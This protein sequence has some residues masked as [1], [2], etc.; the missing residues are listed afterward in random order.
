[1]NSSLSKCTTFS[2]PIAFEAHVACFQF[3][4]IMNT[5]VE[6][7]VEHMSLMNGDVKHFI[8][9]F[10]GNLDSSVETY[11]YLCT[12]FLIGLFVLGFC[13]FVCFVFVFVFGSNLLSSL[14][15]LDISPVFAGLM[16]IFSQSLGCHFVLLTVSSALKKS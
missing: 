3:L 1:M 12:P 6:T 10:S 13:L 8:K 4:V 11:V 14:Y 9:C 5:D 16:K 2:V 7:T 15:I